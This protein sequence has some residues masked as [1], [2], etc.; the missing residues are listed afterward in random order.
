MRYLNSAELSQFHDAFIDMCEKHATTKNQ[1]GW[2][3]PTGVIYCD[4]YSFKTKRG[5]MYIGHDDFV[6]EARWWIPVGLE[7]Q[8]YS[9][10]LQIAFEMC[11]P[12]NLNRYLSVHYTIDENQTVHILHKGK[13][14]VGHGSVSMY[15]FF[16]Y[17][18]K[19][20]G[21]W[22]LTNVHF[23]DYLELGKVSLP[24]T[25]DEFLVL[26]ESLAEFAD[27]I[28]GFKNNYR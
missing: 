17:Y 23:Q 14:A 18:R 28:P 5:T 26:L 4:T 2:G 20:S 8:I 3:F 16:D 25:D 27:Y 15:E 19:N 11:I 7:E 12:K 6:Q 22:P 10:Q 24:I 1:E 21:Q 13:F 9:D